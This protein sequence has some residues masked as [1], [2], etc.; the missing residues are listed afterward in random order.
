MPTLS[1]VGSGIGCSGKQ[2]NNLTMSKELSSQ[3]ATALQRQQISTQPV[4]LSEGLVRQ[5]E[6]PEIDFAAEA[7]TAIS[8][9]ETAVVEYQGRE[10]QPNLPLIEARTKVVELEAALNEA[11]QALA[12]LEARGSWMDHF[13]TAVYSAERQVEAL[14]NH[15]TRQVTDELLR[16]KFGQSVNVAALS[17][18]TKREL[19]MH[20]RLTNLRQF[21][22]PRRGNYDQ[23]TPEYLYAR[24]EKA[25]ATLDAL[26]QYIAKDQREHSAKS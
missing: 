11:R 19:R 5:T 17:S 1:E 21:Q 8:K 12:Q 23:V 18:D 10:G 3:L 25:A 15:Y 4:A 22:I 6:I 13:N 26:R 16:V 7:S 14:L 24:A 20:A 9:L 2:R